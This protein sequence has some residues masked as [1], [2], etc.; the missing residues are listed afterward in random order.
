MSLPGLAAH[1]ARQMMDHAIERYPLESCGL[2]VAGEYVPCE[3][4]ADDPSRDFVISTKQFLSAG[5]IDAVVHSHPN[6]PDHPSRTDMQ[7][8][9]EMMVP[10]GIVVTDGKTANPPFWWG[11][12]L[13]I[14]PLLERTFRHGVSDCYSL[15][16]DWYRLERGIVL[17]DFARDWEWWNSGGD[18]YRDGLEKAGFKIIPE[19]AT[20]CKEGDG[21]LAQIR[22]TVPNHAGLYVGKGLI[23][24]HLQN[25]LS[26]R[27]PVNNWMK[28]ITH[29]VRYQ[30]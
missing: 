4:V 23:L 12:S 25:R 11:D 2:V 29:W 19:G 8:Q 9:M 30:G 24:H 6:G 15:V 26:L 18:L 22:S 7:Q 16:R 1:A 10:W 27:Q 13:P 28:Y 5:K 3:N 17:P 14:Q 20:G 21:F